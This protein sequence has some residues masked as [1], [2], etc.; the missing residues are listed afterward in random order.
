MSIQM[1][2][3]GVLGLFMIGGIIGVIFGQLADGLAC[4]GLHTQTPLR[5]AL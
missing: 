1:E 4:P 3:G 5:P 2:L